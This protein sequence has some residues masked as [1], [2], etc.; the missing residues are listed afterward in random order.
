MSSLIVPVADLRRVADAQR[1]FGAAI[2]GLGDVDVRR[3]TALPGWTAGHLLTHVARNADSHTRRAEAA[4]RG[5]VAD[6][7]IGGFEGRS[8]EIEAG[9]GRCA[10]D[11]I[12]D[13]RTS[14][15]LLEHT[16]LSLPEAA[17]SGVT[18]DVGGRERPLHALV[19]RRWQELEVHLVDL[20][21]GAGYTYLDW[22]DDFVT[23]RLSE[24]RTELAQRLASGV[25]APA[26]GSLSAHDEVAWLYGRLHRHDL[27]DLGPW[28]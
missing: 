14:G 2:D 9:A 23:S 1:R 25:R 8:R 15:E 18:R 13:V 4:I 6:Q 24:M 16:W 28:A 19:A 7:Y 3:P 26:A 11:L 17:W 5:E 10:R 12:D 22:P 27:P 21:L 20:D